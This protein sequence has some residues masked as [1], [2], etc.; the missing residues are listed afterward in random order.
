MNAAVSTMWPVWEADK[1]ADEA[2]NHEVISVK[3][4]QFIYL[5]G[6]GILLLLITSTGNKYAF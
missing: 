5:I 6:T 4:I 1:T 3:M 2:S